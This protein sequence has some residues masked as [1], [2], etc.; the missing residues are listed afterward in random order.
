MTAALQKLFNEDRVDISL[1]P[2]KIV[3]KAVKKPE[4]EEIKMKL[5]KE[6][7]GDW[8]TSVGMYNTPKSL[9][10]KNKRSSCN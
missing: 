5:I 8:K 4:N 9:P 6:G 2:A 3:W 1:I 7:N 10:M